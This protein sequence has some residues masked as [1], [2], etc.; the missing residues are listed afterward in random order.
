MLTVSH[1]DL[2]LCSFNEVKNAVDFG[3]IL[4]YFV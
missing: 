1:A 3:I 4:T 2:G